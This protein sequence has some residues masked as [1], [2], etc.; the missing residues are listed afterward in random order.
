MTGF[1]S[2][3]GNS[4]H[5]AGYVPRGVVL[6]LIQGVVLTFCPPPTCVQSWAYPGGVCGAVPLDLGTRSSPG[7]HPLP[8]T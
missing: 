3:S 5:I 7:G 2:L 6:L 4:M 8:G 1:P